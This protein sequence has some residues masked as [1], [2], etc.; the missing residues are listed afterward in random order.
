MPVAPRAGAQLPDDDEDTHRKG[1]QEE[2][3]GHQILRHPRKIVPA[4]GSHAS[5]D[6]EARLCAL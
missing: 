5:I 1:G 4:I 3:R 2:A 6:K